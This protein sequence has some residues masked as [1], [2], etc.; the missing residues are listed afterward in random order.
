MHTGSSL[1]ILKA[2][3]LTKPKYNFTFSLRYR[4]NLWLW[5]RKGLC[6]CYKYG[7]LVVVNRSWL[8]QT[9]CSSQTHCHCP[10][11]SCN[12]RGSA[13]CITCHSIVNT[14]DVTVLSSLR[15]STC[16]FPVSGLNE[17]VRT[18]FWRDTL[19]CW[20]IVHQR[21]AFSVIFATPSLSNSH[22]LR[23]SFKA[24]IHHYLFVAHLTCHGSGS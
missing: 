7:T 8:L 6:S 15:H 9:G 3:W 13:T 14:V 17:F 22:I 12:K 19:P 10:T 24:G 4:L 11:W 20:K 2:S 23:N 5:F 16:V 21:K 1:H 18:H